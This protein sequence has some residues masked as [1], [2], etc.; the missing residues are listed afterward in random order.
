[1]EPGPPELGAQSLSHWIN[2]GVF[3]WLSLPCFLTFLIGGAI[4]VPETFWVLM[5]LS[6]IIW[7]KDLK[8]VLSLERPAPKPAAAWEAESFFP[9]SELG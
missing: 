1:M 2:R 3:A 4:K 5:V 9:A 7:F 6:L 8:F